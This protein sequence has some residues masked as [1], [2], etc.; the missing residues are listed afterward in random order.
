MQPTSTRSLR[1]EG[2]CGHRWEPGFGGRATGPCAGAPVGSGDEPLG[3]NLVAIEVN[4]G[5]GKHGGWR[6][7]GRLR[8]PQE[9]GGGRPRRWRM[10]SCEVMSQ[11]VQ[12]GD[13]K[14]GRRRRGPF[15]GGDQQGQKRGWASVQQVQELGS[16]CAWPLPT[17]GLWTG[18]GPGTTSGT[19]RPHGAS[20]KKG[21]R[22][23]AALLSPPGLRGPMCGRGLWL[24]AKMSQ[25]LAPRKTCHSQEVWPRGQPL[26]RADVERGSP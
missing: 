19:C 16:G 22:P 20:E 15:Q 5:P 13:L 8:A 6:P 3:G 2:R 26:P 18:G 11:A 4:G 24:F 10:S 25:T 21:G 23:V 12:K 1:H 17:G 7:A 14:L 9:W